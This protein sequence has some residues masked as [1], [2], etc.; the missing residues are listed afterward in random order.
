M[1]LSAP[2]EREPLHRRQIE[3]RGYRRPDGLFD[4]QGHLIDTK[5]YAFRNSE[6]GELKP[7]DPI[8][9]MWLRITI[10]ERMVIQDIEASTEA[11]PY[12]ICPE[13][14]PGFKQL[15]GL[16]IGPGFHRAVSEKLGGNKNCTHIVELLR[17]M[18]TTAYQTLVVLMKKRDA[19]RPA[20]KKPWII[21][22]CYA[23]RSDGPKVRERWTEFYTGPKADSAAN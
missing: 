20:G 9:E 1:P 2:V 6:R 22:T 13:V 16:R 7:G 8:H 5:A 21:D 4:I 23:H 10:D 18:A 3:C 11:S 12:R 14:A 17:P 15:K 19:E